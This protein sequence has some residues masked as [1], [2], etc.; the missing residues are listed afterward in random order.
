MAYKYLLVDLDGTLT[1]SH[2]GIYNCIRYALAKMGKPIPT[3]ES[4]KK[5]IGPPLFDSFTNLFGFTAKEAE[6][7][8]RFY[9]E[10]YREKGLFENEPMPHAKAFLE[11]MH[12]VGYRMALA[13]AKPKVFADR[14]AEEYG[15]T[16]YF[17]VLA[18]AEL[19][20]IS[21]KSQV[22][23]EC[24]RLLGAKPCECL[25]IGDRQDD[26]L[27]ARENGVDCAVVRCG[28]AEEGELENANP[29]YIYDD[30]VELEKRLLE[31][32]KSES[33]VG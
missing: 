6:E 16:P 24:M 19:K 13:T 8:V 21:T 14:I 18:V 25:M 1:L 4:L 31:D 17:T 33:A 10:R 27:G 30:L 7:G 5:V 29:K 11:A 12:S 26:V 2:F 9:R 3:E 23:Q 20:G 28:Y 15:F 22:V 32:K